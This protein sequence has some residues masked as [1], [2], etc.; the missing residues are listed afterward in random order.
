[1]EGWFQDQCGSLTA[2]PVS[3]TF[4][5]SD[6]CSYSRPHPTNNECPL[7]LRALENFDIHFVFFGKVGIFGSEK[8]WKNGKTRMTTLARTSF[9]NQTI[10][11]YI[12][13][14]HFHT[15]WEIKCNLLHFPRQDALLSFRCTTLLVIHNPNDIDIFIALCTKYASFWRADYW[16]W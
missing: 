1:M 8:E 2:L 5:F 3:R 9:L 15:W 7:G 14:K 12:S 10:E 6:V 16:N 13:L 4:N 11:F